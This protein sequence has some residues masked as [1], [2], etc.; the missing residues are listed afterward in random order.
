MR[1]T[2]KPKFSL[3]KTY[4]RMMSRIRSSRRNQQTDDDTWVENKGGSQNTSSTIA[5]DSYLR[6]VDDDGHC[7]DADLEAG[8]G[9]MD[10]QMEDIKGSSVIV[11][12]PSVQ[13]P[14][15]HTYFCSSQQG[16]EGVPENQI[17][18]RFEFGVK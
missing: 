9:G 3:S 6:T 16:R 8:N 11:S 7:L 12:Q 10:H 1:S 4:L 13:V 15:G 18:Q 14:V 5:F 17:C 2:E